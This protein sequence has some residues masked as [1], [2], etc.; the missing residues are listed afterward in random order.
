MDTKTRGRGNALSITRE[1]TMSKREVWEWIKKND[2]A[3]KKFLLDA[4]KGFVA[5]VTLDYA[6][7][8]GG[9]PVCEEI[10]NNPYHGKG[11][12]KW[13]AQWSCP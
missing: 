7:E 5:N 8:G 11:S 10:S 13:R 3:L 6:S 2:P 1:K 12:G 9:Q 4:P